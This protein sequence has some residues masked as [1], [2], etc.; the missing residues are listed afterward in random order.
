MKKEHRAII[1]EEAAEKARKHLLQHMREWQEDICFALWTPSTGEVV[2]GAI[3]DEII[4]PEN[5]ERHLHGGASAESSYI[6]RATRAAMVKGKG[7]AMMHSHPSPGWQDMSNTDAKTEGSKVAKVAGNTGLPLLG[8]TIGTDGYWSA[9]FWKKTGNRK[10][11]K[12]KWC[13]AVQITGQSHGQL[14]FDPAQSPAPQRREEL[15]RTYDTWGE[16][17]QGN[18]ARMRIG[19]VGLGSVGCIIAE[20]MARMGIQEI[21]LIDHDTIETHNLDRLLY[22]SKK[23]IG[24]KKVQVAKRRARQACTAKNP[25]IR[26][27]ETA[28]QEEGAYKAAID[29]NMIFACVD[30]P[31]P[32][33]VLNHIAIA[34]GIPLFECGISAHPSATT[35]EL[36]AA[37]WSAQLVAPNRQCLMCTEQYTSGMLATE[38]D[39]SL[40]ETSYMAALP[41]GN[42]TRNENVF[43]FSLAAAAMQANMMIR[44]F[45]APSWWREAARQEH[46]LS[47]ATTSKESRKCH[48]NC[49][50][51]NKWATGDKTKSSWVNKNKERTHGQ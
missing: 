14:L 41:I 7:L 35:G 17:A 12:A 32:R 31:I 50:L 49:A 27:I 46:Q 5:G 9:R 36:R 21:T 44:Y 29:C 19:I 4:L 2:E 34:H 8:M 42:T 13:K 37:K 45:A 3:I 23:N 28:I 11:H 33:D 22:G 15:K 6:T 40:E 26:A 16:E 10:Q 24:K 25:K 47:T 39:G 30:R 43:P 1:I 51:R 48:P 18:L 20:C 38:A